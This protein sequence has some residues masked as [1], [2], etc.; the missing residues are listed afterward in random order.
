MRRGASGSATRSSRTSSGVRR[1]EAGSK[2]GDERACRCWSFRYNCATK[3]L[4]NLKV[5]RGIRPRDGTRNGRRH[6]RG[7]ESGGNIV[8]QQ[9]CQPP[10]PLS[11]S[12]PGMLMDLL[13]VEHVASPLGKSLEDT[14]TRVAGKHVHTLNSERRG[15]RSK[16][17]C[18]A[19]LSK[20]G[21]GEE[22]VLIDINVRLSVNSE[23]VLPGQGA[24]GLSPST[25]SPRK[26]MHNSKRVPQELNRNRPDRRG[27]PGWRLTLSA[28]KTRPASRTPRNST[29]AEEGKSGVWQQEA[30]SGS[31]QKAAGPE[32]SPG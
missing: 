16:K 1:A 3:G 7:R 24:Q 31:D 2:A 27:V 6:R 8:A 13:K 4:G 32:Y 26:Q 22:P 30:G 23:V 12:I 17:A 18:P 5:E 20:P 14:K 9:K 15:N 10:K 19:S 21:A 29:G 25:E 28:R 11:P